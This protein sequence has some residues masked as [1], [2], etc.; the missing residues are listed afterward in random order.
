MSYALKEEKATAVNSGMDVQR[1]YHVERNGKWELLKSPMELKTGELVRVDLYVS[2]PAA[3]NFV[4]IDDPVPGGLEPVNRDLA[5]SSKVAADKAKEDF[6]GG[7]L[8]FRFSDWHEYAFSL[9]SFYHKELRHHAVIYYSD[10]LAPGNYHLSYVA[11]AISAGEF[12]VMPTHSEEMYSPEVY[13][14]SAPAVLKVVRDPAAS[15]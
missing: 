6:A 14:N 7:S 10:Y 3:R 9:W 2:L 12:V 13:G 8:W 11:Q 15:K 1:E 5:T 4:V